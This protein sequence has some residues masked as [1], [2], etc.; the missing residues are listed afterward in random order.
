M[1]SAAL[2][3]LSRA[4]LDATTLPAAMDHVVAAISGVTR[5]KRA[6]LALPI[7]S[8]GMEIIGYALPDKTLVASRMAAVDVARD[9]YLR[10]ALTVREPFIVPDLRED[11]DADQAQVEF[12][13]V[14]TQINVPM[15]RLGGERVGA[16]TVGTFAAE[17]V[18]VPTDEEYSFIVQVAA[19]VSSA[20]ARMRAEEEKRRLAEEAQA[21]HRLEALGRLAGE[22]AHDFNN[23][24]TAITLSADLM[25]VAPDPA[26]IAVGLDEI[27]FASGR[28]AELTR[29]LLAFS[30]GQPR[31]PR[32]V[33]LDDVV[34]GFVPVLRRLLP[35]SVSL[36][37]SLKA[38]VAVLADPGQLEQVVMNLVTNA[39]DAVGGAGHVALSTRVE[40]RDNVRR[41]VI[42]VSDSGPGMA[43]EVRERVFEPFFTTKRPGAGTGLGLAVV[44]SIARQHR[45]AVE[46]RSS[47]DAGT[48]FEVFL[49]VHRDAL[50]EPVRGTTSVAPRAARDARV[51]V[52]DDEVPVRRLID[53]VLTNAGYAVTAVGDA[54]AALAALPS[55]GAL[56]LV[57]T[58]LILPGMSGVELAK[59]LAA[60]PHAPPVLLVSGYAPDA[61]SLEHYEVLPKPFTSADLLAKV[62]ALVGER[63]A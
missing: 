49:P 33:L 43:D 62:A 34:G 39:R 56:T 36:D 37:V 26:R 52:V 20:A 38:G 42:A 61:T 1:H 2:L 16:L 19:V 55:L 11:P 17:G 18:M 7:A 28:A 35:V 6:W 57:V 22:V 59:R 29:Q 30:R 50:V 60:S 45:G 63:A 10:R 51:L 8:G 9:G 14:R 47:P 25:R 12:F 13:G 3:D 4:L 58:D 54:E 46:V 44:Q 24:L 31:Q 41:C 40:I 32:P 21:N 15:L 27:L 48:T 53:R 5:Y 23:L